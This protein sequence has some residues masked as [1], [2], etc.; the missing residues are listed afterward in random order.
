[1]ST[2]P[3]LHVFHTTSR[4]KSADTSG[5][6][7]FSVYL[8][9]SGINRQRL[10]LNNPILDGIGVSRKKGSSHHFRF[11]T[12][13]YG[14][15]EEKVTKYELET[16]STNG[17]LPS[18]VYVIA[19]FDNDSCKLM[20][21]DPN[22]PSAKW[23]DQTATHEYQ[24]QTIPRDKLF[25]PPAG[26]DPLP[27]LL[28]VRL[29]TTT[30]GTKS[31]NTDGALYLDVVELRGP[32]EIKKS[33]RIDNPED[34]FE[35]KKSGEYE[36]GVSEMGWTSATPLRYYLRAGSNDGWKPYSIFVLGLYSDGTTRLLKAEP[37]WGSRWIDG[38]GNGTQ[39]QE[40]LGPPVL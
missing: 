35:K 25:T 34:D 2:V 1:M 13:S 4:S 36:M 30:A 5:Q 3:I 8:R 20:A 19:E 28:E 33:T 16:W 22:W 23:L 10:E 27:N 7:M 38:N 9:D 29:L 18:S 12:N 40:I 24:F 14:I 11:N 6:I 17:W 37:E 21:A 31:S 26:N 32:Q 15:F 39:V